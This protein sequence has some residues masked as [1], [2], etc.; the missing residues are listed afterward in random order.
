[1]DKE[2]Y[3][4]VRQLVK[5]A[6]GEDIGKGDLTSLACLEPARIKARISA[7]SDGVLSGVEP[8]LMAFSFVD[9]ANVVKPVKKDG[10]PFRPG[11]TIIE[12]EGFNQTVLTAERT[13][14]NFLAH[15]SGIATLT[16][17]FVEKVAGTH[18][19]IL[20][21]RK[22]TPGWRY[23]EKAAVAH[24]GGHNHR[25]G[26]YDM[27]LIKDN[28][29]ASAGTIKKAV[30]M[31]RAFLGTPDF[32]LQFES[33]EEDIQIEVEV[34]TESEL[35]DAIEA[36]VKRLLLDNQSVLSLK[37]LVALARKL[38]STVELEASGNVTLETVA[39]IA[40]TGVDFISIGSITH[41]AKASDFSLTVI[42]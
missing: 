9:S 23:L 25:F 20:D 22:T 29:I 33:R 32:R 2:H 18:C 8:A 3:G 4:A 16:R 38:D 36:G 30:E 27:V 10:E 19:R 1:M 41:S 26:L 15:L 13:A 17:Q 14:L 42:E 24:G 37:K 39:E 28:H 21:T 7:K 12:I 11:D 34:T 35:R 40:A 6:L 5:A 31:T